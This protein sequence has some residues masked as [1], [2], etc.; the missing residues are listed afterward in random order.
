LREERTLATGIGCSSFQFHEATTFVRAVTRAVVHLGRLFDTV[1]PCTKQTL[2]DSALVE[3]QRQPPVPHPGSRTGT[4]PLQFT[5]RQSS[6]RH[7]PGQEHASGKCWVLDP[8]R[9]RRSRGWAALTRPAISLEQATQALGTTPIQHADTD[10]ACGRARAHL[11]PAGDR[12]L[13][14]RPWAA[15]KRRK[16]PALVRRVPIFAT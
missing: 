16:T 12:S 6:P 4:S 13:P 7:G 2:A 8:P 3:A 1:K 10:E 15:C 9:R 14:V 5:L 11:Q